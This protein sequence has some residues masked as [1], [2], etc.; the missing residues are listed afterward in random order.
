MSN[1]KHNQIR[2]TELKSGF[3]RRNFLQNTAGAALVAGAA[4]PLMAASSPVDG[5]GETHRALAD[6]K[7]IKAPSYR[8]DGSL[9]ARYERAEFMWRVMWGEEKVT[10]NTT[11]YPHWIE[12]G[13]SFWYVRET[14][15]TEPSATEYRLVDVRE[16]S[17]DLAF[18]HEALARGL[19]KL[20]GET[21]EADKLPLSDVEIDLSPRVAHFAAFQRRWQYDDNSKTVQEV[22]PWSPE[23][24][25]S[26]DGS[27]AVFIRDYNLWMV[28][29]K[30][31][32][33]H[34]LTKDGERHY[35]YA[36]T[37][38]VYGRQEFVTVEALW[39]SDSKRILTLVRDTR[40]VKAGPPLVEY[41]PSDGSIRPR[42]IG[43][44]RHV[45]FLKDE[46]VEVC[47][48]LAIDANSGKITRSDFDSVMHFYPAYVGLFTGHRGWW[49]KD[50]RM[51]YYIHLSKDGETG[52]LIEFDTT[53]GKSR[54][55]IEDYVEGGFTFTPFSHLSPVLTYLPET[56]EL[57]WYSERSGWGHLYLY[58]MRTGRQK[59]QLTSGKWMVRHI[60]HV[61]Q[62][63][64]Q[65]VIQTAGRVKGRNPYYCDISQVGLDGGTL[66]TIISTDE[67]YTVLDPRSRVAGFL[68][69]SAKGVS[70]NGNYIVVTRSRAD[71]MPVSV[72][73][74]RNGK[75][76]MVLEEATLS[77]LPKGWQLPEPVMLKADDGKTDICSVIFRPS[78]FDPAKSYP[79]VDVSMGGIV[80][81][82]S[83][84]NALSSDMAMYIGAAY[85]ELGFIAVNVGTRGGK[86]RDVT[87][88]DYKD[89]RVPC[90]SGYNHND[91][92]AVLK[93]LADLYPY[94]DMSRIGV[95]PPGSSTNAISAL[96]AYPEFFK[97]GVSI[98][99]LSDYRVNATLAGKKGQEDVRLEDMAENLR[100][101]LLLA[102]GMLDDVIY[103]AAPLR[104]VEALR[105]ADKPIDM[106]LLPNEGHSFKPE[107]MTYVWDY[108]VKH[109]MEVLPPREAKLK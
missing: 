77:G 89:P 102:H 75:Q 31:G 19:E 21:V 13:D 105:K 62:K 108:L 37:A 71:Q 96:L 48:L 61:D 66:K 42:D 7:R 101:K 1:S 33:E 9:E 49:G 25:I 69:R 82:G 92:I 81:A 104:L 57:I 36:A 41:V 83:F 106:L 84:S 29:L 44:D 60:L 26:P 38:S 11:V 53:N 5:K 109:L 63:R 45:A 17:N 93:Q 34:P 58:D 47:Y 94:M 3:S 56:D 32:K 23:W 72:L 100:G 6:G 43:N 65:L 95:S 10:W 98:N 73:L 18:D 24:K 39:S 20:S 16:K 50:N 76:I 107:S 79:V 59:R 70:A 8:T 103:V 90:A 51:A 91:R 67:E 74:D 46:Q 12:G 14:E 97:V 87:F 68:N 54:I 55:L 15:K 22:K 52:R 27:K 2:N 88:R 86:L 30:N 40:D 35:A 4:T 85:A 64:R 78:D 99:A 80:S 28:D